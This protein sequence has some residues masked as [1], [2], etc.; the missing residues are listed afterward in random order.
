MNDESNKE[1]TYYF[2]RGG[3]CNQQRKQSKVVGLLQK[4]ALRYNQC[5]R[6]EKRL[7]AKCEVYNI[8]LEK[9]GSFFEITN[10]IAVDVT[11]D[12][13]KST[14][15][16]MQVFRDINKRNKKSKG[17]AKAKKKPSFTSR[18]KKNKPSFCTLQTTRARESRTTKMKIKTQPKRRCVKP[19]IIEAPIMNCVRDALL[20]ASAKSQ[21]LPDTRTN[22]PGLGTPVRGNGS[23]LKRLIAESNHRFSTNNETFDLMAVEPPQLENSFSALI[24]ADEVTTELPT[25]SQMSVNLHLHKR[26]QRLE[27]LVGMLMQQM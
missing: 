5:H 21:S 18:T 16:I 11:A 4:L 19:S 26:V 1:W 3:A 27:N 20:M 8:V 6:E 7:F 12:E 25:D 23:E 17:S 2:G 15:K 9:G 10:K 24:M 13:M 14:T 22:K